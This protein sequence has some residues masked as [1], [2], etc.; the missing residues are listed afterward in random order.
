MTSLVS[1]RPEIK[2]EVCVW[3]HQYSIETL[4]QISRTHFKSSVR[5]NAHPPCRA[6]ARTGAANSPTSTNQPGRVSSSDSFPVPG[7]NDFSLWWSS[8]VSSHVFS[9]PTPL[10]KLPLPTRTQ[11][12][13]YATMCG[14]ASYAWGGNC[15]WQ[16]GGFGSCCGPRK[17]DQPGSGDT[18]ARNT[19]RL[20]FGLFASR[21]CRG[22]AEWQ[23]VAGPHHSPHSVGA[24]VRALVRTGGTPHSLLVSV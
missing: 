11:G 2:S 6:S 9:P 3:S 22:L 5:A 17:T 18:H 16:M 12:R 24:F 20:K 1:R 23:K 7:S 14:S 8:P 4:L 10:V 13:P 21:R 15:R 19:D